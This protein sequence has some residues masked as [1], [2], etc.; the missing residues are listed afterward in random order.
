MNGEAIIWTEGKT[1]WQHLKH[2]LRALKIRTLLDFEEFEE[3]LGDDQLLKQCKALARVAQARSTI[4]VFDRDRGD[5]VREVEDPSHGYKAWGNNVFSFA[6][7]IPSH[8]SALSGV[9]IE[10]Y[11]TDQELQTSDRDGRRLFLSSEFNARSG[12]HLSLPQLSIGQKGKLA[13]AARA[14]VVRVIDSEVFNEHSQNVALSKAEFAGNVSA[15][16]DSFGLFSFEPFRRLFALVETI[17]QRSGERLD[18]SFG[19]LNSFLESQTQ[20]DKPNQF[21][22]A[23]DAVIR[24]CKL[25]AMIF[26]AATIRFYDT[27]IIPEVGTDKKRLSPIWRLLAENFTRPTLD[28]LQKLARLCYYLVDDRA[29]SMLRDLRALMAENTLLGP[30]GDML[31]DLERVFPLDPSQVRIVNKR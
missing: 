4:F 14:N 2:A 22:A 24:A 10:L 12:R 8:R 25:T 7:P 1:D 11:Y 28:T 15:G 5:V 30:L 31:D 18:L 13:A 9:C 27:T 29:P 26:A 23:V 19:D 17:L 20:K 21:A 6:I 3:H 16:S